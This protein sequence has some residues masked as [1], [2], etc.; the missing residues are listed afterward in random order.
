MKKKTSNKEINKDKSR[1]FENINKI[2]K[3]LARLIMKEK[4]GGGGEVRLDASVG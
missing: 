2:D 1:F 4:K 3:A